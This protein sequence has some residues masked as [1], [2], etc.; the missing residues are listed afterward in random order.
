MPPLF[1]MAFFIA[2]YDCAV[3]PAYYGI[4][5]CVGAFMAFFIAAPFRSFA[6]VVGG[7]G[8]PRVIVVWSLVQDLL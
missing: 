3:A 4:G 5:D 8:T 6:L 2:S 1:I 7:R